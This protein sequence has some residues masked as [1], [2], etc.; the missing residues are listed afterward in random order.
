MNTIK[1]TPH[2]KTSRQRYPV[3]KTKTPKHT[4]STNPTA[5]P[6]PPPSYP[7]HIPHALP[8]PSLRPRISRWRPTR[9]RRPALQRDIILEFWCYIRLAEIRLAKVLGR[10]GGVGAAAALAAGFPVDGGCEDEGGEDDDD[11]V[12]D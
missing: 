8:I 11:D 2:A 12:G 6:C 1:C 5:V 9:R 4:I 10:R 7:L 3:P